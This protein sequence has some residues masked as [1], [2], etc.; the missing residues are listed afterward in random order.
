VTSHPFYTVLHG[1][2]RKSPAFTASSTARKLVPKIVKIQHLSP[3]RVDKRGPTAAR[4]LLDAQP[5]ARALRGRICCISELSG[6]TW[7]KRWPDLF[8]GLTSD[9]R[10]VVIVA[11][12]D[13]VLEGWQPERADI[14]ALVD[15]VRGRCTTREY[16]E[17]VRR[18]LI[19]P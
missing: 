16:I 8:D 4:Q 13:N 19:V 3:R 10:R 14:E 6:S 1:V 9:E 7:T 2:Q 12:A 17:R 11:V 5:R 18:D 15:V